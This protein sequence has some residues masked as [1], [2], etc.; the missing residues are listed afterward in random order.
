MISFISGILAGVF[1]GFGLGGG[2][3]LV[4]ILSYVTSYSQVELQSIN[5]IYYVPAAAF[6]IVVYM[7]DK[8]IDYKVAFKIVAYGMIPATSCAIIA[9]KINIGILRKLF[10]IYLIIIG[11][12]ITIKERG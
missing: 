5:L 7:R 9:N 6:S 4:A 3:I 11:I 1:T 8:N 10:A 12:I 2:V